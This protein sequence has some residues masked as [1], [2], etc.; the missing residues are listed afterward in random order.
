MPYAVYLCFIF[1]ITLG[2]V[3]ISTVLGYIQSHENVSFGFKN[4]ERHPEVM[5]V[6]ITYS[7]DVSKRTTIKVCW[8]SPMANDISKYHRNYTDESS[9]YAVMKSL[10]VTLRHYCL[11]VHLHGHHFVSATTRQMCLSNR[12]WYIIFPKC[13]SDEFATPRLCVII[14]SDLDS[15]SIGDTMNYRPN[16][17]I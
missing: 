5:F 14:S 12:G 10:I 11:S 3:V 9:I 15:Q 4:H 13:I 8:C 1:R 7:W 17:R 6:T 2:V 16:L